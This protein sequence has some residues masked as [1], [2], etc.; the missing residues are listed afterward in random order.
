M[1][2]KFCPACNERLGMLDG[3]LPNKDKMWH[4]RCYFAWQEGRREAN[5]SGQDC[6]SLALEE[7]QEER[8]ALFKER[9][10]MWERAEV[11]ESA[12]AVA[13]ARLKHAL[14]LLGDKTLKEAEQASIDEV[15]HQ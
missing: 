10:E 14:A 7:Y 4:R 3:V 1:D 15:T 5:R 8:E 6:C 9:N 12:R 13:D 11:A 2:N